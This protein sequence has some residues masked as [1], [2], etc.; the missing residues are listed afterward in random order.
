[1]RVLYI[2]DDGD[3]L[4][5][6]GVDAAS[7]NGGTIIPHGSYYSYLPAPGDLPDSFSYSVTDNHG[8]FATNTV[9]ID[10]VQLT[11]PGKLVLELQGGDSTMGFKGVPGQTYLIQSTDSI[12]GPWITLG[13]AQEVKSG[14]YYF[15][16]PAPSSSTRFYRV[17]GQ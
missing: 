17:V 15:L 16:D 4:A 8:G 13:Q 10:V 6:T 7:K 5:I 12:T 9:V 2:N 3:I 11:D 1:M 14:A